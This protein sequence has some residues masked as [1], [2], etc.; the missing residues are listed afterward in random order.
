MQSRLPRFNS[1]TPMLLV[2]QSPFVSVSPK[3]PWTKI[4]IYLN[5]SIILNRFWEWVSI[6]SIKPIYDT[7]IRSGVSSNSIGMI[8]WFFI[9]KVLH[10]VNLLPG[11]DIIIKFDSVFYCYCISDRV[12]EDF[13]EM[14]LRQKRQGCGPSQNLW[15]FLHVSCPRLLGHK[16]DRYKRLFYRQK[17][18]L[19]LEYIPSVSG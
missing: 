5:T 18:S 11:A 1:R 15:F 7:D 13:Q 4:S 12:P 2:M 14:S 9:E 17:S 16:C 6:Y 19:V 8:F 10:I 3:N